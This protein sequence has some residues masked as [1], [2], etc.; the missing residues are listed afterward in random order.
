MPIG[1]G[2][3]SE[4]KE[5]SEDPGV[6][7]KQEI[8]SKMQQLNLQ[9]EASTSDD[10]Q[11]LGFWRRQFQR[12]VTARQRIFDWAFGVV[13]PVLCCL[14]DPL[15]F[16]GDLWGI[17]LFADYKPFAYILSFVSIMS[18]AT[19]LIWGKKLKWANA[20]FA[21]LFAVGGAVSLLVGI[22]LI[23]ISLIGLIFLIG[24][25]GFTP[26]VSSIIYLRNARRAFLYA[27]PLFDRRQLVRL[28]ATASLFSAVIPYVANVQISNS[29]AAIESGDD[30]TFQTAATKL[31]L[32]SPLVN[33]DLLALHYQRAS[34]EERQT[35]RM[36]AVAEFYKEMTGR[37]IEETSR[38]LMD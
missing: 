7:N 6:I 30:R 35:E 1:A 19:W 24:V 3:N 23:P 2:L 25:L 28:L 20:L 16:K 13:I 15:V 12:E 29:V 9:D 37:D 32:A 36:K 26:L 38:V 17:A 18:M 14:F 31:R 21:G 34:K 27:Y 5:Q 11:Q 33:F 8:N 4:L 10:K 22:A